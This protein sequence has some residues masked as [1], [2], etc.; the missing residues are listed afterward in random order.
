MMIYMV[1]VT[2]IL[3]LIGV[4]SRGFPL[5]NSLPMHLIKPHCS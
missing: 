5:P 1:V 4:F 3:W 2:N